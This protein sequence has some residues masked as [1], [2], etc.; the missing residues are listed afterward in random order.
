MTVPE[1]AAEV[2]NP[3]VRAEKSISLPSLGIS[4]VKVIALPELLS[5]TTLSCGN[6]MDVP[7]E[8]PLEVDQCAISDQLPVPP[9]QYLVVG[10]SVVILVLPSASPSDVPVNGV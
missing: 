7:L 3:L 2:D 1:G 9:I 6:G 10:V 8:P 4:T 5:K